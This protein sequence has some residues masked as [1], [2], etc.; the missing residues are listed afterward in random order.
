[1]TAPYYRTVGPDGVPVFH[2]MPEGRTR[3][4]NGGAGVDRLPGPFE[5]FLGGQWVTD[6]RGLA[7]AEVGPAHIAEAHAL[8]YTEALMVLSGLA[9][10]TGMLANEATEKGMAVE[11]LAEEVI[12]KRAGFMR[13]EIERQRRQAGNAQPYEFPG[14]SPLAQLT[15][16]NG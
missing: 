16:R 1:M 10:A 4:P 3:A 15:Q 8:K 13:R 2:E 7:D 9:P 5:D 14:G 6:H 11:D 12:A